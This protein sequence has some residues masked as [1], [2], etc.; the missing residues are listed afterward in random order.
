VVPRLVQPVDLEAERAE[1]LAVH[2]ARLVAIDPPENPLAWEHGSQVRLHERPG[3]IGHPGD[4][5][6]RPGFR[7]PR[8]HLARPQIHV[9]VHQGEDCRDL[10]PGGEIGRH[11]SDRNCS[12]KGG[13]GATLPP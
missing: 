2:V 11:P 13:V 8:L 12:S 3:P 10:E 6:A 7:A 5:I 9:S 4:A 1:P